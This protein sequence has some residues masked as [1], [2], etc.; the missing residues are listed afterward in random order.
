MLGEG[1]GMVM[2]SAVQCSASPAIS[3]G[4]EGSAALARMT[5]S[6]RKLTSPAQPAPRALPAPRWLLATQ[7]L[8]API[9]CNP[10]NSLLCLGRRRRH[11]FSPITYSYLYLRAS[12]ECMR[13]CMCVHS[14]YKKCT[15]IHVSCTVQT[16]ACT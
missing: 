3:D 10:T 5:E 12:Y 16:A 14:P 2:C 6:S 4:G 7:L 9:S 11:R 15:E 8:V 13:A 1:R